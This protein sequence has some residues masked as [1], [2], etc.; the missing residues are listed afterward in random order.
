MKIKHGFILAIMMSFICLGAVA[1]LSKIIVFAPKGEKFTLFI[2]GSN[3]NSRPESRVEADVPSGPT[4]KILVTF[5][6]PSIKEISKL[7]FNKINTTFYYKVDKNPKGVYVLESTSSEWSDVK[8]TKSEIPQP[9]A[10]NQKTAASK[11]NVKT[12]KSTDGKGCSDPMEESAFLA[13]LISVSTPPFDPPKLSAAKKLASQHCLT[14][15]Q[16]K[17]VIYIFESESTRLTFA[18][19]AYDHTWDIKNYSDVADA[20]HSSKSKKDL[21]D[22]INSKK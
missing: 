22:Y 1:Q 4:F 20:L 13:S 21:E 14:T 2:G 7:V 8:T 18:K 6:D 11:E 9:E 3:Q 16:V 15:T 5:S 12:E 19:F 10:V 17:E